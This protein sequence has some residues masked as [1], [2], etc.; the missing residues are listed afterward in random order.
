[1]NA[2]NSKLNKAQKQ[3]LKA[4][5]AAN[6]KAIFTSFANGVT[7]L[8]VAN[9]SYSGGQFSVSIAS[10]NEK[11]LRRKVGE[12]HAAMRFECGES[13]PYGFGADLESM[14]LALN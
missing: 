13:L 8:S 14:A 3:K 4:F 7:L 2:S 12:F 10:P 1:M 6:P 9:S 11:K 5:K